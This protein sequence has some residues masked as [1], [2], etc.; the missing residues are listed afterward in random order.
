MPLPRKSPQTS[1]KKPDSFKIFD[2]IS[3]TSLWIGISCYGFYSNILRMRPSL[4]NF[5][6][7]VTVKNASIA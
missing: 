4:L 3:L 5:V 2:Q 7:V 1:R 6:T